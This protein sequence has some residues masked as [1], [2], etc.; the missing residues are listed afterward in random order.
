M[1]GDRNALH[2]LEALELCQHHWQGNPGF[3]T[4]QRSTHTEVDAVPKGQVA[5][6]LTLD[7]KPIG[8]G[9]LGRITVG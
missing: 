1:D 6:R 3:Q 8:I 5:I 7:S 9:E 2:S 4:S